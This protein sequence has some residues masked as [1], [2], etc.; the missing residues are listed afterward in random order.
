M[1]LFQL[2]Q[3]PHN[4]VIFFVVV[5]PTVILFLLRL[6]TEKIVNYKRFRANNV[7][8]FLVCNL[9]ACQTDIRQSSCTRISVPNVFFLQA[10]EFSG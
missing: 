6:P 2:A 5:R 8:L 10:P 4:P 1:N 7:T 9:L 3:Q